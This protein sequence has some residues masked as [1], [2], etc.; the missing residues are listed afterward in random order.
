MVEILQKQRQKPHLD[1]SDTSLSESDFTTWLGLT[2]AQFSHLLGYLIDMRSST[3]RDKVSALAMF[4]VKMK[5]GLSYKQI[6]T[7]FNLDT[8]TK[9]G[10]VSDTVKSVSHQ[11]LK[12]F[13]PQYLGTS[14]I[15]RDDAKCHN[16]VY[17][18]TFYGKDKVVT[19]CD[20]TYLYNVYSEKWRL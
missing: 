8:E 3:N 2:K 5:T 17:T 15:T 19:I 7:L 10:H 12:Y 9:V 1:F 13:V 20:G 16:T 4:W 6:C 11:L 14:S 18:D